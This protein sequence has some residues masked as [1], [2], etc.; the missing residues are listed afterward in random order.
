M[1]TEISHYFRRRNRNR[2]PVQTDDRYYM[3]SQWRLMA[4]KLKKHKL[5]RI[6]MIVLVVLYLSALF[7]PFLAPQGPDQL[8]RGIYERAA[9]S[10]ALD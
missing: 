10:A 7:A 2:R 8:R 9:D 5:A 4:R 1:K 6:S 3:A